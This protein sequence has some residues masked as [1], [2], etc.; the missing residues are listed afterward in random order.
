MY[1]SRATEWQDHL[2]MERKGNWKSRTQEKSTY[3]AFSEIQ[4][5][6]RGDGS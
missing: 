3:F 6:T 1:T 4:I 2:S 5:F